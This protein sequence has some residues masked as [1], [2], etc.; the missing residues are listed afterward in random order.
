MVSPMSAGAAR[1]A[2]VRAQRG[3]GVYGTRSALLVVAELGAGG[4][5]EGLPRDPAA[6]DRTWMLLRRACGEVASFD[7]RPPALPEIAGADFR[8]EV[9]VE[10]RG[11][12]FA[13]IVIDLIGKHETRTPRITRLALEKNRLQMLVLCDEHEIAA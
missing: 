5:F 13:R 12:L 7:E 2:S 10:V 11:E 8:G 1:I 4:G 6:F 3:G 9:R